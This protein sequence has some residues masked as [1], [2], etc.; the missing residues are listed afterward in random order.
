VGLCPFHA[1]THPSL[2]VNLAENYW[3]CF[4]GCGGGTI[5]DFYMQWYSVDVGTAIQALKERFAG[6]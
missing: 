5:I 4:A 1:D 3:Q 6:G 2:A